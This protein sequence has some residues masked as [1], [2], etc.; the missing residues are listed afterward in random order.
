MAGR[1]FFTQNGSNFF[2]VSSAFQKSIRRYDEHRALFYAT[3][4]ELSGQIDY[5]WYRMFV[6]SSEDIGLADPDIPVRLKALHEIYEM[7]KAKKNK[8]KPE[9]LPFVHAVMMLTRAKKSRIVDNKL[10]M[11]Y[12]LRNEIPH[13]DFPDYT[14]DMHTKEGKAKGRGNDYFYFESAK[15]EN[16]GIKAVPDEYKIRDLVWNLY[17][18]REG[19]PELTPEQIEKAS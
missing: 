9:R 5:V 16:V 7:H 10:C 3:E 1:S 11:Y 8:H 18:K 17:R 2:H 19:K 14:F 12:D 6:I 13:P 4:L 15:I